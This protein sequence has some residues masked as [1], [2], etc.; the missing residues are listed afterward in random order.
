[1]SRPGIT[2]QDVANAAQSLLAQGTHPTIEKIRKITGTGS[3]GTIA[4]LLKQWKENQHTMDRASA[5]E[6]LPDELV[7]TIKGLWEKMMNQSEA[8]VIKIQETAHATIADLEQDLEKYKS[9]NQRWQTLYNQWLQEKSALTNE[10]RV[11]E[12][13]LH[14]KEGELAEIL[15]QYEL[16]TQQS[17]EKQERILE[18]QRLHNQVQAN[19]EHFRESV[20]EQRMIEEERYEKNLRE[21][22]QALCE[23][24]DKLALKEEEQL[25]LKSTL[26]KTLFEISALQSEHLKLEKEMEL[27]QKHANSLQSEHA[28]YKKSNQLLETE[29][30]HL[31]KK[32]ESLEEAYIKTQKEN[33]ILQEK[34]AH[35]QSEM[36]NLKD[37][38]KLLA[39]QNWELAQEKSKLEGQLKQLESLLTTHS[40]QIFKKP[41][42]A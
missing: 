3:H 30:T 26:D 12:E 13:A 27:L 10:K 32:L 4:P 2:Y 14:I 17:Q 28:E 36:Q 35:S 15:K 5:K 23:L 34:I 40:H 20:R 21:L 22:T 24:K 41:V 42:T 7:A 1:M 11:V 38:N 18:L 29:K 33:A 37:Q 8:E 31:T 39:T 25:T 16:L 9:N 6:K 19:L